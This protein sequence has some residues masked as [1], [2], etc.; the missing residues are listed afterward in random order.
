MAVG[1]R[2]D[3]LLDGDL[4]GRAGT[5]LDD[6]RLPEPRADALRPVPAADVETAAWGKADDELDRLRRVVVRERGN[7]EGSGNDEGEYPLHPHALS[8]GLPAGLIHI[9]APRI[10]LR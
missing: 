7:G 3:G 10:P 6:H 8:L 1:P 5:V 9:N 4:A 2:A